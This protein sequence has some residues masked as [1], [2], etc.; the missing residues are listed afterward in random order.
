MNISRIQKAIKESGVDA[1]VLYDFRGSNDLAWT[2]AELPSDAHCTRR[3]IIVIP[4][5][6]KAKKIVHRM[7]RLPLADIKAEE[8]V[9]STRTE[10]EEVLRNSLAPYKT[11]AMEYSA[12]C[13]IPVVS[14]VDAGTIELISSFGVTVVS[15]A[16]LVQQFTAVLS[17]SQLAGAAV[18]G[19]IVRDGIQAGFELIRERLLD[20][21]PVNEYEVQQ[22]VLQYFRKHGLV[23]D[24]HPIVAIGQNAASPHYAPSMLQSSAI[25]KDMVVVIDAWAKN[26]APGS[27]YGD[28]TWVGYTGDTIPG[29]VEGTFQIIANAR[30]AA[31]SLVT[32][33]FAKSEALYGYEVD[34]AARSVIENAGMGSAFIH[35][36]GHNITTEIH[37]PGV[38]MDDY[39]THD[40]RRVL[41]G[42]SFS[43][44][45]GVYVEGA[46][47]MR[48]EI[49]V[50][51]NHDG[52]VSVPSA[53]I[54][55]SV[56][57]LLANDWMQ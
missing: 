52:V 39:E 44:E 12:M 51:V 37:G 40:D 45:P 24:T 55:R 30:D 53:P 21:D 5:Q 48:T 3:W 23:T 34:N 57:P 11:I 20:D 28:L 26:S 50:V 43:I 54:Q 19:G 18:T 9:Y 14:K 4:S 36:T 49:D 41:P 2:M 17:D 6:G 31:L 15:S 33:R 27:V 29:D 56:L 47:G 46:L 32:I 22:R 35:R 8:V 42:M 7:E 25:K 1:W 13:A 16:D 38:N 10:Y